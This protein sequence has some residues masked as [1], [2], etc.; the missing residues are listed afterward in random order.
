VLRPPFAKQVN[1]P[2]WSPDVRPLRMNNLTSQHRSRSLRPQLPTLASR[3]CHVA[4]TLGCWVS[5]G[6]SAYNSSQRSLMSMISGNVI[7]RTLKSP[8]NSTMPP[9]VWTSVISVTGFWNRDSFLCLEPIGATYTT[10]TNK[11]GATPLLTCSHR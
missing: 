8:P 6:S 4:T 5:M 3:F 1:S 9:R 11:L 7:V 2:D 10:Q